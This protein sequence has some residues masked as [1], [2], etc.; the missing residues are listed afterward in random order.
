VY[1][2]RGQRV[3]RGE[4]AEATEL[5]TEAHGKTIAE[6]HIGVTS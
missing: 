3:H 2:M 4:R 1:I 6:K 5:A